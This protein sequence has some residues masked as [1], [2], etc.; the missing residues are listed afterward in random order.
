MKIGLLSDCINFPSLPLMKISAYHKSLGDNVELVTNF[1]EHYEICYI[2]KVFNLDLKNIP[3]LLYRPM[4]DKYE[5]GG[6]GFCIEIKDGREVYKKENDKNLP[7]HIEHIYPDYSLYPQFKDTAYGFL[8]R[9]CPNNCPFCVVS[10]KEGLCSRK[11]ADLSEFWNGQN[12]VKLLDPNIL[13][14]KEREVL[15]KQLINSR[16]K[17]DY[18]QG[19]DAR[20]I[21][22]DIAQ[23]INQ[24][25]IG[26]VHFAF[27]LMKN[28]TRILNGLK[29]FA[30]YSDKNERNK[31]VYILTNFDTTLQEDWYRVK[32]VK[33]LGYSPYVMIYQKGTH[34]QFLTDLQRWANNM[35]LQRSTNFEDYVPRKDGKSCQ[36][37]YRKILN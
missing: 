33:E 20:L 21:D 35:Y 9:G 10:K 24:T 28:E 18:T 26:M 16:A 29:V 19:L 6:S 31:R 30:K 23:L 25:K 32:K 14:C 27:D 4:A 1:L 7:D 37:L 11:V 8:T 5:I 34:P 12:E 2:S 3:Q 36:I 17:V 13:A 15:L 22:K